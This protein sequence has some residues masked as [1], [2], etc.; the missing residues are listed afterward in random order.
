MITSA[1][2]AVIFGAVWLLT[3]PLRALPDVSLPLYLTSSIITGVQYANSLS[4]VIPI[5]HMLILLGV[6]FLIE[7]GFFTYEVVMWVIRRLPT[8]S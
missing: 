3:L 1:I 4:F 2:L 8:Q 5:T 7:T 6:F